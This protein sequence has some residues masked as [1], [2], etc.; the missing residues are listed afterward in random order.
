MACPAIMGAAALVRQYYEEGWY[1]SGFANPEDAFVPTGALV[2]A[3]LLNATVDMDGVVGYP[4]NQEGWGR[5]LLDDALY[6]FGDPRVLEAWDVR[7]AEG[8]V[9]DEVRE[10]QIDTYGGGVT[11]VA[12]VFTDEPATVGTSYAPVNDLD[13]EVTDGIV[14]YYGNAVTDGMSTAIGEPDPLNN[15]EM[16]IVPGFVPTSWTIRVR[17]P[18]VVGDPQGFALVV[19]GDLDNPASAQDPVV[20]VDPITIQPNPF[21]PAQLGS[22]HGASIRFS[23]SRPELTEVSIHDI[24]GRRVRTLVQGELTA[25]PQ[26]VTWDGRANGDARLSA[27]SYFVRIVTGGRRLGT[28]RAILLP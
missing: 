19:T 28:R 2:K 26:L 25:G 1:P 11:R 8:M 24:A 7:H 9:T 16:V 18:Q 21:A 22:L 20:T 13:L 5:L 3:T 15:I 12:L 17:A 10:F 6:F 14:T 27:G 4:S 23:L